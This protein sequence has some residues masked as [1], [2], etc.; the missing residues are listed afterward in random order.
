MGELRGNFQGGFGTETIDC[1]A[2]V[3][4]HQQNKKRKSRIA[5]L[6]HF[7][8]FLAQGILISRGDVCTHEPAGYFF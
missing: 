5:T 8:T 1:K 2:D 4:R 7:L 6:G 3:S